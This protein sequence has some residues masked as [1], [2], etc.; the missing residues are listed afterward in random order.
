MIKKINSNQLKKGM[1]V[2]GSDQSWIKFP[3]FRTKFLISNDKDIDTIKKHCQFI[4]ID[5][6]KGLDAAPAD[7]DISPSLADNPNLQ[8]VEKYS[9]FQLDS[10]ILFKNHDPSGNLDYPRAEKLVRKM[11][12][13]V[14]NHGNEVVQLIFSPTNKRH[15][16][17]DVCI[18]SLLLGQSCAL[19]EENKLLLGLKGLLGEKSLVLRDVKDVILPVNHQDDFNREYLDDL[20]ERIVSMI[21]R[22]EKLARESSDSGK[23][24]WQRAIE[25]MFFSDE[26]NDNFDLLSK[27]I[28]KINLFP[29]GCVLELK[30]GELVIVPS[31][32]QKN[33]R[34]NK[35]II[36]TDPNKEIRQ[37]IE[38]ID[39]NDKLS[40]HRVL[41]ASDPVLFLLS[42]LF[43]LN[44]HDTRLE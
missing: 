38:Y 8:L 10:E 13:L 24:A 42:M 17:V 14:D 16:E 11:L 40:I 6:Q 37:N 7:Q 36:A 1:F 9:N 35:L 21:S 43:G 30:S 2:C 32:D 18:L 41:P 3:F 15:A 27:L 23:S 19:S 26:Y 28:I 22:Y 44:K 34:P 5:T 4:Y 12:A 25:D 31:I 20:L 33:R 39:S 29:A